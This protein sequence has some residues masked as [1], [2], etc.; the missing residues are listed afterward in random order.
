MYKNILSSIPGIELYPILALVLFFGFFS[1]LI[2]WFF[3]VDTQRMTK[4]SADIL[5]D[6]A[7]VVQ[8]HNHRSMQ[9][10]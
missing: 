6:D 10:E 4:L 8:S 1:A 5:D 3:A 9:G 2:Y 7:P